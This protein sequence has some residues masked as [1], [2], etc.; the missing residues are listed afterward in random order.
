MPTTTRTVPGSAAEILAAIRAATQRQPIAETGEWKT[1][2]TWA[3]TWGL[4]RKRAGE[5][6]R[7]A[8]DAGVMETRREVCRSGQ[9]V[10]LLPVYRISKSRK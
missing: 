4:S 8:V 6:C 9:V 1:V 7:D 2:R 5:I 10:R 3:A